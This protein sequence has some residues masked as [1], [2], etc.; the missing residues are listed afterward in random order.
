VR[1]E[2][3]ARLAARL[4]HPHVVAVFDLVGDDGE[5]W[6]V[7]E[8]VEGVTL[9]ELARSRGGLPSGEAAAIVGQAAEALA[10]A[11]AA[12][13][14]HRDV[15]PSNIMVTTEGLAKLTDFGIARALA[16]AT[17][18]RT[19]MVTGSPAYLAPEVAA[20]RAATEAS[21]V[22][23]LGA[24]LFH[25]L[26]GRP[27]YEDAGNPLGVLYRIVH[28]EIP[29]LPDAGWLAP[30]LEGTMAR[31]QEH[32]WSM[33]AVRDFLA[34]ARA[35]APAPP[36]V[37]QQGQP[38]HIAPNPESR[39]PR[40]APVI[41]VGS[42]VLA[43]AVLVLLLLLP[44]GDDPGGTTPADGSAPSSPADGPESPSIT[45]GVTAEGMEAFV[46]DYLATVTT[47]PA[48]AWDRLTPRF[49]E[50]SGG[51]GAYRRF[52]API[53]SATVSDVQTD[54]ERLTVEYRVE[55][56]GPDN[57]PEEDLVRLQLVFEDGQYLIDAEPS[58]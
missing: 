7:M 3:A 12:G 6:L 24:T 37:T 5:Q 34:G 40:L 27:P 18:T 53:R 48:A 23:A 50:A 17:L 28:E 31:D 9:A 41:A 13:I 10:A 47:D 58:G 4:N 11:H 1:P 39:R 55:Y 46:R 32:R 38:A 52:W 26:S 15:K 21:D 14:V 19:G 36:A 51:F 45:S 44:D 22:W 54:P 33:A 57:R 35:P 49:Q 30:L 29:R 2:R 8:Y 56:D 20:G 16:D 42:A 43:I 25:A